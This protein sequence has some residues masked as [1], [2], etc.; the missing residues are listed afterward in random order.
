MFISQTIYIKRLVTFDVLCRKRVFKP[1]YTSLN[2]HVNMLKAKLTKDHKLIRIIS[3]VKYELDQE[4]LIKIVNALSISKIKYGI[5]EFNPSINNKLSH[6][7]PP[8]C[9]RCKS[10]LSVKHIFECRATFISSLRQQFNII[11]FSED[12]FGPYI[13]MM[14]SLNFSICR[15]V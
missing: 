6:E 14:T 5:L 11:N 2:K 1:I 3:N 15:N 8:I 13:N 10:E 9:E 4:M 7:Q 12:I